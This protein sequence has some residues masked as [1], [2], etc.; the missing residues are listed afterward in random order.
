M[1]QDARPCASAPGG[2]PAPTRRPHAS[3]GNGNGHSR[4]RPVPVR[5]GAFRGVARALH[6]PYPHPTGGKSGYLG[7]ILGM[8]LVGDLL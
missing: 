3:L 4:G 5:C 8:K 1:R 2:K 7:A 6:A